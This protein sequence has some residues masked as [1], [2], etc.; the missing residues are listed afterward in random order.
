M[1]ISA[2][3]NK[4]PLHQKGSAMKRHGFLVLPIILIMVGSASLSHAQDLQRITLPAPQKTGGTPLMEALAAR[5]TGRSFSGRDLPEQVLSNL[6]WAAFGVNRPGGKRTA[7]SA[8]NWQEVDVYVAMKKGL[9]RYDAAGHTLEPVAAKDLRAATGTQDFVGEAP[10]NLVFVADLSKMGNSPDDRK[11]MVAYAD[12]GFISQNVYLFCASEGLATVVRGLIDKE[13]LAPEMKL[14]ADQ[15]I[16][17]A[18][19][20][21]YPQ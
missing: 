4:H 7:P 14:R 9:Y 17:L 11:E 19:T 8:M 6:L 21:G 16:I 18:Q 3:A 13:A 2:A 5:K 1:K 20:V 15:R 12:T 10:I